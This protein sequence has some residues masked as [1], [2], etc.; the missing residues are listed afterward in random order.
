MAQRA[1]AAGDGSP[2]WQRATA[3]ELVAHKTDACFCLQR[4]FNFCF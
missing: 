3:G 1:M 2:Q 4:R